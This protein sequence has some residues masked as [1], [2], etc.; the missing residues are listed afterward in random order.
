MPHVEACL[1]LQGGNGT[2]TEKR[3]QEEGADGAAAQTTEKPWGELVHSRSALT[4]IACCS[5]SLQALKTPSM[6]VTTL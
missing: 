6:V 3:D 4:R 1:Y 2:A 5:N